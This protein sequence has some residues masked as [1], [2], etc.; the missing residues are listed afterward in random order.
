[1]NLFLFVERRK[2]CILRNHKQFEHIEQTKQQCNGNINT[3]KSV[4]I[5]DNN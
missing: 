1:M 4:A 3:N 2:N 5:N